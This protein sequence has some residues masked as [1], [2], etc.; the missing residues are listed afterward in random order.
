MTAERAH[1]RHQKDPLS[2]MDATERFVRYAVART[3][4]PGRR[5]LD[6]ACGKPLGSW[7]LREWGAREVVAVD[8]SI[9]AMDES[10]ATHEEFTQ[11]GVRVL[12]SEAGHI[13]D[14][15]GNQRYDLILCYDAIEHVQ[16]P[17][18][19]LRSLQ[20]LAAPDAIILL[21][22]PSDHLT[23][24]PGEGNSL[25][26]RQYSFADFK[27]LAESTLGPAASW[28]LGTNVRGF[29]LIPEGFVLKASTWIDPIV[30]LKAEEL[31]A[32]YLL[33]SQDRIRPDQDTIF[34]CLGVWGNADIAPLTTIS[35]QQ[36]AQRTELN[37]AH[38]MLCSRTEHLQEEVNRLRRRLLALSDMVSALGTD[39]RTEQSRW[40]EA[41]SQADEAARRRD[42]CEADL[43][44][45]LSTRGYRLLDF[46]YRLYRNPYIGGPL[47]TSR[48]IVGKWLRR[49]RGR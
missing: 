3:L 7:L 19:L 20:S 18:A 29:T 30:F 21:S 37:T 23:T 49:I 40:H 26:P 32:A 6:I 36:D 38:Q 12:F 8:V 48:G 46:Y 41:Q 33:L 15:V 28:L 22:Y 1:F 9:D 10:D 44:R 25:N 45:L 17:A 24:S 27:A 42:E 13:C 35:T 47:K 5:V 2:V 11:A 31:G 16:D 43:Q 39:L 34:F 4:T 14:A